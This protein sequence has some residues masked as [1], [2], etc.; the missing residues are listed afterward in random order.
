MGTIVRVAL[1][2]KDSFSFTTRCNVSLRYLNYFGCRVDYL[3]RVLSTEGCECFE[4]SLLHR[5]G[6]VSSMCHTL[7]LFPSRIGRAH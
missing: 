5:V 2:W 3:G 4:S 1:G 6:Q 7:P